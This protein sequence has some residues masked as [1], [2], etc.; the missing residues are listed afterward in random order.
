MLGPELVAYHRFHQTI[1][2]NALLPENFNNFAK[3]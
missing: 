3:Q 2:Y 1:D